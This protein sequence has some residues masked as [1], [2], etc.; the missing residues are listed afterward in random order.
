[1]FHENKELEE[2]RKKVR[3]FAERE[4]RERAAECD[5]SGE[6]PVDEWKKLGASGYCGLCVPAEYG[7]AGKDYLTYTVAVEELA[8]VNAGLAVSYEIHTS[9][10]AL[11]IARFGTDDQRK[12]F[13]P[14]LC[15]GEWLG[16]FAL[17]EKGAGTDAGAQQT[18]AVP[19]GNDYVI[20]G[21]KYFISNMGFPG[22]LV[23]M[24]MTDKGKGTKGISA[25]IVKKDTPGIRLA[26]SIT[27]MGL[28]G[29]KPA[30]V[31][32]E[33]VR[34]PKE[35][36]LGNEG[37]GFKIALS[38]LD[39]GRIGIAAQALGIA[40]NALEESVSYAKKRIQFGKP[41]AE[42]QA[43]QWMLADMAT[44]IQAARLLTYNAAYIASTNPRF[45]HHASMAKLFASDC[46][47]DVTRKAV[48]IHGGYG[49]T[50]DYPVE[51]LYREAKITEIYEGTSEVQRMV[52]A[53][54]L[55]R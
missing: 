55:L 28:K 15:S 7:G 30:E 4:T 14:K 31:V 25:F 38:A 3:E 51:R 21:S 5:R 50:N 11:T 52:I 42:M 37:D 12:A 35:N 13:L 47:V 39:Y 46:A 45:S 43:I 49:Y 9:L 1:M 41:I 34:V 18:V 10:C 6:Y 36:R 44:G 53:G 22:A 48:Q 33:N 19:D 29:E 40:Q 32:L 2:F 20:N 8:R 16:A 23:L 54:S 26:K 24:A 17:T 27:L